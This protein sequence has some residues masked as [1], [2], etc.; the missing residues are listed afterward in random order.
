[1]LS[2]ANTHFMTAMGLGPRPRPRPSPGPAPSTWLYLG[3]GVQTIVSLYVAHN[4]V[5]SHEVYARTSQYPKDAKTNQTGN[6]GRKSASN[7][8]LKLVEWLSLMNAADLV[9]IEMTNRLFLQEEF[10][11]SMTKER[12]DSM[13]ATKIDAL[14]V[15]IECVHTLRTMC[16]IEHDSVTPETRIMIRNV[17][18][19]ILHDH[20]D[21][22]DLVEMLVLRMGE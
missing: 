1:M 3:I 11:S 13:S 22:G 5:R 7:R 20:P 18:I 12:I 4:L 17:L 6:I 10:G 19:R 21:C 14:C 16:E 9:E 2:H 8:P 15:G